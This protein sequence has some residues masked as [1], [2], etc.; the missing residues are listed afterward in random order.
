MDQEALDLIMSAAEGGA[1][2]PALKL[3]LDTVAKRVGEIDGEIDALEEKV[4]V[5]SK[6]RTAIVVKIL[7]TALNQCGIPEYVS[8]FDDDRVLRIKLETVVAGSLPKDAER[9]AKALALIREYGA[10]GIIKTDIELSFT[11]GQEEQADKAYKL[12]LQA[13]YIDA[14]KEEGVHPQTLAGFARERMKLGE[15]VDAEVLGLFVQQQAKVKP[16]K[17]KAMKTT[18]PKK[19]KAS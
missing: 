2:T 12:L 19:E 13:G 8:E 18:K 9:R 10:A 4:K 14:I 6:E 7:P 1:M 15:A 5:L 16:E 17:R 3:Q 11:A